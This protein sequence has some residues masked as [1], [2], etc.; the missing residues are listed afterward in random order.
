MAASVRISENAWP[1]QHANAGIYVLVLVRA[2][3]TMNASFPSPAIFRANVVKP[4][5]YSLRHGRDD[6]IRILPAQRQLRICSHPFGVPGH[7][8]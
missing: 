3:S 2:R 8:P 5:T 4:K 1:M 7:D 6:V